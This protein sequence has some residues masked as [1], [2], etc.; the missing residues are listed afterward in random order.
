MGAWGCKGEEGDS[1][2]GKGQVS[3]HSMFALPH[4][5]VPQ[6][7]LTLMLGKSL[8]LDSSR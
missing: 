8:N 4:R 1:Q 2:G 7:Y 6:I 3:G 5:R